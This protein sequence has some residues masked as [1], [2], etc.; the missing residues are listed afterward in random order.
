MSTKT[1]VLKKIDL[2]LSYYYLP[3]DFHILWPKRLRAESTHPE[4]WPK[5]PTY[6]VPR[7]KR[8]TPKIGRNDP[9]RNDSG[10]NDPGPKRPRFVVRIASAVSIYSLFRLTRMLL[11][12]GRC[13]FKRAPYIR[14]KF[15]FS[16]FHFPKLK[17]L[18]LRSAVVHRLQAL[19]QPQP[20]PL[21]LGVLELLLPHQPVRKP[22]A[23]I[24]SIED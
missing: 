21:H 7:P 23:M 15:Q 13:G 4:N 11:I 18:V 14:G 20:L 3:Y 22:G 16:L 8:P 24:R 12:C 19:A 9:G 5:R 10:R 2:S 1:H 6:I 17:C